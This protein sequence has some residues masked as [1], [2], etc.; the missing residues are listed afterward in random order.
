MQASQALHGASLSD[1]QTRLGRDGLTYGVFCLSYTYLSSTCWYTRQSPAV[2]L[3]VGVSVCLLPITHVTHR[4]N[5]RSSY[6]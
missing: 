3:A 4:Q 1:R 2:F 6:P 5:T